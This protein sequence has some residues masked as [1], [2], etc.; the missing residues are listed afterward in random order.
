M[1]N[2]DVLKPL[3]GLISCSFVDYVEY[4]FP[5]NI[6]DVDDNGIIEIDVVS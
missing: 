2:A 6:E 5:R 4:R 1:G 3:A